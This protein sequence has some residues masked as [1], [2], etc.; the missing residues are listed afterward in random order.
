MFAEGA[1]HG[2]QGPAWGSHENWLLID[3]GFCCHTEI[4]VVFELHSNTIV[5]GLD[6]NST[7]GTLDRGAYINQ[8]VAL[9]RRLY[10]PRLFSKH[11]SSVSRIVCSNPLYPG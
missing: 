1:V 6:I 8:S 5:P 9:S 11:M 4:V 10:C 2:H 3:L 7:C